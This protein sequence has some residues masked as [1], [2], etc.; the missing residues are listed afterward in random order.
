SATVSLGSSTADA[1]AAGTFQ[2]TDVPDGALDLLASLSTTNTTTLSSSV[3]KL[4]IRRGVNSGNNSTL[5]VLDF[6]SAE[7]FDP[8][9]ANLTIGNI[10]SD[11]AVVLTSYFTA[12]GS[13]AAGATLGGSL[14]PGAGPFT[15]FGVPTSEQVAGD[16]HLALAI[17]F[18]GL[19]S[20]DQGRH[21][22]LYFKDP[23]DRTV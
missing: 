7:A 23:T 2:L 11:L 18:P 12:A 8:V 15:Y 6:S 21:A 1:S 5:P 22:A 17:A 16:L 10:G 19:T 20:A 9:Q 14:I 13:G 3:D 4:I